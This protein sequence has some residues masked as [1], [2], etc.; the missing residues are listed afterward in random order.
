VCWWSPAT[1]SGKVREIKALLGP[2]GIE[3][4]GAAELGLAEPEETR[5]HLHRQ[6]RAESPRRPPTPAII[7]LG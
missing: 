5:F 1:N 4:L 2:H 6:R 7:P 3:P